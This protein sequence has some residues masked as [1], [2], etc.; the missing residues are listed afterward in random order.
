[1]LSHSWLKKKLEELQGHKVLSVNLHFPNA[2]I[3]VFNNRAL[4]LPSQRVD[5]ITPNLGFTTFS[6]SRFRF[7][8]F[9]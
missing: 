5:I 7:F 9:S 4:S 2:K 6:I 1:L 8:I 3:E